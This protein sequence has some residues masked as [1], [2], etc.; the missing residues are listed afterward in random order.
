MSKIKAKLKRLGTPI[1]P[2]KIIILSGPSGSGKT[3]LHKTLLESPLFKDKIV[4]SISVTTR[5]RRTGEREG[6]DY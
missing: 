6:R 4:K 3:T 1:K 5:G 2:G